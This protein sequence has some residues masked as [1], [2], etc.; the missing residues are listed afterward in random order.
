MLL[1][2]MYLVSFRSLCTLVPWKSPV[3][4]LTKFSWGAN[5]TDQPTMT[6]Q[7]EMV[8]HL[9]FLEFTP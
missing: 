3:S 4:L 2:Y 1:Q 7:T 6:L 9:F 5:Q 8:H